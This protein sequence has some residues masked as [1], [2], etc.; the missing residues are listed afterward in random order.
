MNIGDLVVL[1]EEYKEEFYDLKKGSD[2][3][4]GIVIFEYTTEDG[5]LFFEVFWSAGLREYIR[6]SWLK[7]IKKNTSNVPEEGV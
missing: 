7:L 2:L 3:G 5:E 4:T 6:P 1:K